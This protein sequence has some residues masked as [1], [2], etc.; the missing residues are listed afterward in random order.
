MRI[1]INWISPPS[2]IVIQ[3]LIREGKIECCE[4]MVDNFAHLPAEK[5]KEAL[6]GIPICLHIVTS[7]FLEKS[8]DELQELAAQL[9]PWIRA[10]Q[11]LYVSDHL[12]QFTNEHKQWL[13]MIT[14]LEYDQL[15]THVQ[16]RVN[17]W[18]SLLDTKIFFEN[19]ASLTSA[20]RYQAEFFTNLIQ[21]T[22]C[23]MLFDFSNAFIAES[24]QVCKF[25]NWLPLIKSTDY[26]HA[27]GYRI[28]PASQLLLDTHDQCLSSEVLSLIQHHVPNDSTVILEFDAHVKKENWQTDINRLRELSCGT[29]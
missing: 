3:Q 22:G 15:N 28:D 27:G 9:K 18:Q 19:H 13:P 21:V 11:P 4:V 5:I 12:V 6:L 29:N 2:L 8:V 7:R 10:L 24:N 20:G 16:Q 1:G 25:E 23:G 26:F 17:E 14:E